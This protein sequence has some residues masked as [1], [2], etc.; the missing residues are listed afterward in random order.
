MG[1]SSSPCSM[2]PR[3]PRF[4]RTNLPVASRTRLSSRGRGNRS[5]EGRLNVVLRSRGGPSMHRFVAVSFLVAL[6]VSPLAAAAQSA[7]HCNPGQAPSFVFGFAELRAE[8]GAAMG[9]PI[10]CEYADP[11]GTGDTLQDTSTGLAF[12]RKSTNTP[13]FTDGATHWGLTPA[14]F[15][16]WTGPS[17]DPPAGV[18]VPPAAPPVPT[19]AAPGPQLVAPAPA[20]TD[21]C[22]AP[23]NPWGYTF[24]GGSVITN[25][26]E[27]FCS[28]FA[29]IPSFAN[30]T[31]GYIVQ[32]RDGLF[33]H[34]GGV[35]GSCSSH[36][37]NG[38]TLYAR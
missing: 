24:C 33:S 26:P 10:S 3:W 22:G 2:S 12:W 18:A 13:T 20:P 11:N 21:T 36:G 19:V 34:S 31:N 27:M 25:P 1:G 4:G 7:P 6:I 15:V 38:Q 29:C 23:A 17:I 28:V 5:H 14:G 9:D 37:G 32:C 30:Q 8:V 35:Q 16:A